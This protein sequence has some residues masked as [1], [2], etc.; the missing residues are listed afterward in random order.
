MRQT[1]FRRLAGQGLVL[2]AVATT[3]VL[4]TVKPNEAQTTTQ[5]T[6][7]G[8]QPIVENQF[9]T[10][11]GGALQARAPGNY[12]RQAIAVQEGTLVLDGSGVEDT[13]PWVRET[14][15]LLFLQFVGIIQD[16]VEGLNL[17]TG[18][19]P[20]GGLLDGL[21]G[22]DGNP[23]GGLLS[24]PLTTNPGTSTPIN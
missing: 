24:N 2:A 6:G 14:F 12:T 15:D 5:P 10:T 17:A 22:G 4:L 20:L 23:L 7:S 9:T 8:R 13:T 11:S 3:L 16:L 19:N 18:G 21:T 1:Y